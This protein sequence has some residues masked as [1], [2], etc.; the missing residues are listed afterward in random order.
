MKGWENI[1]NYFYYPQKIKFKQIV[2]NKK[3]KRKLAK[4]KKEKLAKYQVIH[5]VIH[6]LWI[7]VNLLK[8]KY[9]YKQLFIIISNKSKGFNDT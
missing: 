1:I 7:Y 6:N 4:I 9:T 8:T 3:I 2:I 5:I